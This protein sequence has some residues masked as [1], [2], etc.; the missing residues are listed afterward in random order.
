MATGTTTKGS[1]DGK[2]E[3]NPPAPGEKSTD[4]KLTSAAQAALDRANEDL[5]DVPFDDDD[6]TR[7]YAAAGIVELIG[8]QGQRFHM[9][10][11][12][13]SHWYTS[14]DQTIVHTVG[15]E[16]FQVTQTIE[17]VDRLLV[18]PLLGEV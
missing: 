15:G 18:E 7:A 8:G 1:G 2:D 17:Q 10:R 5:D 9:R 12:A 3:T 6:V 4:E 11:D 14:G 16:S 13:A